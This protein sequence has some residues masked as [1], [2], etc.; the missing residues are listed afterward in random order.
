MATRRQV[1]SLSGSGR[2]ARADLWRASNVTF[3]FARAGNML[4]CTAMKPEEI[5]R[6]PR[7]AVIALDAG[8]AVRASAYGRRAA[9]LARLAALGLPV[10]PGVALS[11]ECVDGLAAGGRDAGAAARRRRPARSSRCAQPRGARLGRPP[12]VL[13]IGAGDR[14]AARRSPAA[15]GAAAALALYRPLRSPSFGQLVH[16]IDAEEFEALCPPAPRRRSTRAGGARAAARR[17]LALFEAEAGAPVAAGPGRGQVDARGAGDGAGVERRLGAH[18]APGQG[19]ARGRRASGSSCS[20]W[21]S[22]LGAGGRGSGQI[23]LVDGRTGA[24]ACRRRLAAR[25]RKAAAPLGAQD[26]RAAGGGRAP[27]RSRRCCDAARGAAAATRRARRRLRS[28][29]S[30]SRTARLAVVDALPVRRNA[31]AAVRIAVDLANAGAITREEALLRIEPR[32]LIEHLHPQIDPAAPRDVFATGLAASPGAAT[33]RIVFTAEAAQ[34]AAAQDEAT[35]LV[36]LETSPEDIRGMHA[37]RGV[38]TVR[39]GMTSHAAVI[40]RGIGLPCVVGAGDLRLDP[41]ARTLTSRDGRMLPRGGAD[42]RRR[43]PR[44]GQRRRAGDDPAGARRRLLRRCSTGPTRSATSG[45]APTPT[46]RPRRGWRASSASTAS[47]SAAPST[48]S[49]SAERIMVM[50][51]MILAD[52]DAERQAALDKLLPMQR[53]DFIELFEIMRGLPVTIRLL[54][55]PL[56]EFLPQGGGRRRAPSPRRWACPLAQVTARA[57]DLA[58]VNP[59]LGMRGVRLGITMPAIYEMQARAIFEAAIAV[60]RDARA[61]VVPE[62]MI[63]LVSAIREVELVKARIDAIAAAVQERAGRRADLQARGHGRDAAGGAPRRGPRRL[64]GLPVAS[65]PT[66]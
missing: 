30:S 52:T 34:A 32:S 1:A 48:C 37:A 9:T 44:R 56:H 15:V 54:D 66:T 28:S 31:R 43:H 47:G 58:E 17:V 11:F 60:N 23:Q 45:S 55:P 53:A 35:I 24:P 63:P 26:P 51:E 5:I 18:P 46:P 64:L 65:G 4:C 25:R 8:A 39:G 62:V 14:R 50:R 57:R 12:A 6:D 2:G 3:R 41:A 33:G 7:D 21:R 36:R 10:P 22:A 27:R 59:M 49:S 13:N 61:P 29:S 19:R 40:A 42:H 16:G 20:A 38:L